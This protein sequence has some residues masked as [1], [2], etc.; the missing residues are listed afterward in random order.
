ML[1]ATYSPFKRRVESSSLS[2]PTN[3]YKR[4]GDISE[5]MVIARLLKDGDV[6]LKP[7]GDNERFDLVAYSNEEFIRIQ[8]K[9]GRLKNGAVVFATC[10]HGRDFESKSYKGDADMFMVYCPETDKVYAVPVDDCKETACSLRVD[11][12]K[13]KQIKKIRLAKDFEY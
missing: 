3:G 7:F 2:R 4:I 8:V 1:A 11:A 10:N 13:N 5:A 9:T 12:P 6:V